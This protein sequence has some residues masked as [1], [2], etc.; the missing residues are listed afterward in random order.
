MT[1]YGRNENTEDLYDDYKDSFQYLLILRTM[2]GRELCFRPFLAVITDFSEQ[3]L[4][5]SGNSIRLQNISK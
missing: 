5:A 4:D 3:E 2:Q 1:K